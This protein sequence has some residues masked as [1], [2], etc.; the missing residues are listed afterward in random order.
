MAEEVSC[1]WTPALVHS[2]WIRSRQSR[3]TLC[4]MQSSAVID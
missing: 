2:S 1:L 4:N 3:G